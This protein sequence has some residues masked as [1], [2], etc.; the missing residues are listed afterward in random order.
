MSLEFTRLSQLTNNSKYFDAIQRVT[1]VLEMKQNVTK[2]PGLWPTVV[3]A[4]FVDNLVENN[5]FTLSSMADSTYEYLPKQYLLLG[6]HSKQSHKMYEAAIDTA[7]TTLFYRPMT[8]DKKDILLSG[9]ASVDNKGKVLLDPEGQHLS[10]YIPGM[11]AIGSKV[12]DR[13]DD[14][15]VAKKLL[16]GCLWAS[17]NTP[18]GIMPEVFHTIPCK[19]NTACEWDKETWFKDV[20]ARYSQFGV[21]AENVHWKVLEQRLYPGFADI[22]DR[23]YILRPEL[24]E[25]MFIMYR[26][27]GDTDIRDR[28][29]RLWETIDR[30]TK[31]RYGNAAVGDVTTNPPEHTDYMESFWTAETL[32]YFYLMFEDES[33]LSLDNWVFSTEA[34]PFKRPV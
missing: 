17:E 28:A 10:C 20:A 30:I 21:T 19:D 4:K 23:R 15:N 26:I 12:F 1:N 29:W 31:S 34:H 7:K 22:P 3:N 2:I 18:T 14:L 11:L 8:K 27:T 5:L 9:N 33:V 32:K 16:D 13:V 6:G 24:I 25:S